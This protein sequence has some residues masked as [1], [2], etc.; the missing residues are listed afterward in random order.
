[1]K[2]YFPRYGVCTGKQRIVKSFSLNDFQQKL[3]TKFCKKSAKI[4]FEIILGLFCPFK[5]K[6]EFSGK[7]SSVTL[8]SSYSPCKKLL[9]Q[10]KKYFLFSEN[11]FLE[12]KDNF[13]CFV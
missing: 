8:S 3:I 13:L 5:S 4:Y 9:R 10:T 2:Q 7:T 1:M 6:L 11:N 12:N